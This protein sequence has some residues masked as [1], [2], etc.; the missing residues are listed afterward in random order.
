MWR[1]HTSGGLPLP[2]ED[3]MSVIQIAQ[4][5]AVLAVLAFFAGDHAK[6]RQLVMDRW[7]M[8]KGMGQGDT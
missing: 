5:V 7:T 4:Y 1:A 2:R 8:K 3:C 6:L